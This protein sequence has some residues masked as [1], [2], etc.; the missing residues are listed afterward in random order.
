L[1]IYFGSHQIL[2]GLWEV[3]SDTQKN[4]VKTRL[5]AE[6]VMQLE[7]YRDAILK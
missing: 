2:H 6:T 7:I 1:H 3:L 4:R 5:V